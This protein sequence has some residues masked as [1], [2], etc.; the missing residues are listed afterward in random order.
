ME[1]AQRPAV[2]ARSAPG[3]GEKRRVGHGP[4]ARHQGRYAGKAPDQGG[5]VR[6]RDQVPIVA[7]RGAAACQCGGKGVQPWL[8]PVKVLLHP[9]VDDQLADGIAVEKLQQREK[10]LRVPQAEP[11]FDGDGDAGTGIDA[12][13]QAL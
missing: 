2:C 11:G 3:L 13:Q 4:P 5:A 7:H 10:F 12:V 1:G 6:C 9:G 8:I